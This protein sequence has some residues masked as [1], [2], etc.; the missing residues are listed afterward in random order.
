MK[1]ILILYGTRYGITKEVCSRI[2]EILENKGLNPMVLNFE[3]IKSKK[4]LVLEEYDGLL[5]ASGIKVGKM[6][7]ETRNFIEENAEFLRTT[8]KPFGLFVSSGMASSPDKIPN[9]RKKY[10]EDFLKEYR[11]KP[12]LYDVF[13]GI[14]DLSKDS[15]L[16]FLSKKMVNMVSKQDP[17]IKADQKNDL[18]DWGQIQGFVN[19]FGDLIKN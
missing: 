4:N 8:S 11:I 19:K 15:D 7:K 3:N 2:A 17:N 13:G 6:T 14:I 5:L 10:I 18:R 1:K 9:L 12:D 16:G